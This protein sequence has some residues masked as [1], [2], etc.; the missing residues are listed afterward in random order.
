MP[1]FAREQFLLSV[2]NG[3]I[4][5]NYWI[6]FRKKYCNLIYSVLP[7]EMCYKLVNSIIRSADIISYPE[8]FDTI[9]NL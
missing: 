6:S 1:S 9:L 7:R 3:A 4:N 8:I 2:K 5:Y